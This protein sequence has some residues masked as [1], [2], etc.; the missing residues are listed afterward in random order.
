MHGT[1]EEG[2]SESEGSQLDSAGGEIVVSYRDSESVS[3]SNT[4]QLPVITV[5]EEQKVAA[6]LSNPQHGAG[7]K[8]LQVPVSASKSCGGR[9]RHKC[10][11]AFCE[12]RSGF[13]LVLGF[14]SFW[15]FFHRTL[16]YSFNSTK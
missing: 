6:W 3:S 5:A 12:K 1:D 15:V 13:S 14:C 16:N 10:D 2:S 9:R 7:A 4:V 11:L 8:L